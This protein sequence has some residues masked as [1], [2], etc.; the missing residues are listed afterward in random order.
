MGLLDQQNRSRGG[1]RHSRAG[2]PCCI[3]STV[4]C[5]C[6]TIDWLFLPPPFALH[7]PPPCGFLPIEFLLFSL[8]FVLVLYILAPCFFQGG[9]C[10]LHVS[11]S[12]QFCR[13]LSLLLYKFSRDF[14]IVVCCSTIQRA[15]ARSSP[16]R[17]RVSP[18]LL[19]YPICLNYITKRQKVEDLREEKNG[20]HNI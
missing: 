3:S 1:I 11:F 5:S 2:A 10:F 7:T 6:A 4:L 19:L 9:V 12:Q 16:F 14:L 20:E 17:R 8:H 15:I 18:W 13:F